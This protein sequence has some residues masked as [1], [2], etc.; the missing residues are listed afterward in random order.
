MNA[1]IAIQVLPKVQEREDTRR[2]VDEVI[3]YLSA[4]GLHYV[5]GP[6]ETTLEGDLDQLLDIV[7]ECQHLCIRA[8]APG[9]MS[10]VKI[11]YTPDGVWTIDDK[12][13]KYQIQP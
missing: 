3:A 13:A 8:G 4:T 2:I 1:S 6:F 5:V 11:S 7:K 10:Y 12:T 9:V